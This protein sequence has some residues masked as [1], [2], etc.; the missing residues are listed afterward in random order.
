MLILRRCRK[1]LSCKVPGLGL[2]N[3]GAGNS[4]RMI[5]RLAM[6]RRVI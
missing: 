2:A 6:Q 5:L 3:L 4:S 1:F